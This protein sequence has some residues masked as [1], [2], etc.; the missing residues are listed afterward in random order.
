[1]SWSVSAGLSTPCTDSL[2]KT[3]LGYLA[4]SIRGPCIYNCINRLTL[5]LISWR[6]QHATHSAA[7]SSP[8]V[9]HSNLF[10]NHNRKRKVL[11][12][13]AVILTRRHDP[14]AKMSGPPFLNWTV[15]HSAVFSQVA[16]SSACHGVLGSCLPKNNHLELGREDRSSDTN[17][18][19]ENLHTS[20]EKGA[21]TCSLWL[22]DAATCAKCVTS[23]IIYSTPGWLTT[24]LFSCFLSFIFALWKAIIVLV[25]DCFYSPAVNHSSLCR[26]KCFWS[27][28]NNT[29][30][31]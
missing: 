29:S 7:G 24:F 27:K 22:D 21:L 26:L 16:S 25:R 18:D 3:V 23:S 13:R 8:S 11:A 20:P 30:R 15:G 12:R 4:A 5:C 6:T 10:T 1:M 2:I 28:N 19:A 9:I 31:Y 17:W 14:C